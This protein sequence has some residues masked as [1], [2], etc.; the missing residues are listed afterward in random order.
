MTSICDF[1]PK[2]PLLESENEFQAYPRT[3]FNQA[4]YQK[5]EFNELKLDKSYEVPK[6]P[7][8]LMKHQKIIGR[9]LN[10]T[11][12][13]GILLFHYMGSGKT[14]AAFSAAEEIMR[15]KGNNIFSTIVLSKNKALGENLRNELI[16]VCTSEDMY[17]GDSSKPKPERDL[18]TKKLVNS[19][20]SF[21]TWE[22]LFG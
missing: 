15:N 5:K 13:N 2:Y 7:G 20:Y 14:C 19:K 18:Q 17:K 10:L 9:F 21:Y 6:E 11:P 22:S 1:L 12:Y 4:I 16:N 3:D 8:E